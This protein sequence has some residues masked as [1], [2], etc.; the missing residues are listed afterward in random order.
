MFIELPQTLASSS[1]DP[2]PDFDEAVDG[3]QTVTSAR[4]A[5]AR[6]AV[7]R[8]RLAP[9][10]SLPRGTARFRVDADDGAHWTFTQA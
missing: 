7:S 2:F 10:R 3:P 6:R 9:E 1:A 8:V 5:D 4:E